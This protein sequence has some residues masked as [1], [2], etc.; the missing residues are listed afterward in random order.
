MPRGK[1]QCPKC[2]ALMGPRCKE[3]PECGYEFVKKATATAVKPTA[4]KPHNVESVKISDSHRDMTEQRKRILNK[5]IIVPNGT[6]PCKPNGFVGQYFP[7]GELEGYF[8]GGLVREDIKDWARRVMEK[9]RS[10]GQH[11]S[12]EA[13]TYWSRYFWN[14]HD[15]DTIAEVYDAINTAFLL[16]V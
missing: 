13:L 5:N 16:E 3:C 2:E 7:I 15:K 1:K 11:Y 4:V 14:V 10:S 12:L 9:G 6:P 8:P